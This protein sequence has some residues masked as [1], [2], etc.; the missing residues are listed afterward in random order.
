M[1]SREILFIIELIFWPPTLGVAL[2]VA[3]K[4]GFSRQLGWFSLCLL[5]VFRILG[6][7]TG[8]AAIMNPDNAGVIETS[9]ICSSVGLISLV[10]ALTGLI[11]RVLTN[12]PPQ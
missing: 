8:I 4:Q 3:Y 12:L 5:G 10:G 6:A 7:A 11:F 1:H 9:M 2:Y